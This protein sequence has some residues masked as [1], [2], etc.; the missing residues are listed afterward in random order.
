VILRN[1]INC[2]YHRKGVSELVGNNI[3]GTRSTDIV[4]VCIY[5]ADILTNENHIVLCTQAYTII[6]EICL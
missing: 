6:Q 5:T 1:Y 2:M 4:I 3:Y